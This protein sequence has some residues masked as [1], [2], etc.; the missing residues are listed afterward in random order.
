MNNPDQDAQLDA[1][2]AA[3]RARR[4]DTS[5]AEFA[6]ETRL[7]ARLRAEPET[8]SIWAKV[9]WRLIP[10][11]A[12]GVLALT[13][14]NSEIATESNDATALNGFENPEAVDLFSNSN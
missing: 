12:V 1:L 10:F 4:P 2:F 9:S 5:A 14:W 13:L 6:F 7:L 3:A 8:S 11:F